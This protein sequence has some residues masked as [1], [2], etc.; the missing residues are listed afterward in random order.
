M[1]L[2]IVFAAVVAAL[3]LVPLT[4]SAVDGVV[5]IDQNKA[6]AGGITPGDAPGFPVTIGRAGSYRLAGNLTLPASADGIVIAESGVT[7]DLNGFSIIGAGGNTRGITDDSVARSR[8][9]VRNGHITGFPSSV[10][11]QASNRVVIEQ[12][13]ADPGPVGLAIVVGPFSRLHQ[14]IAGANGLIQIECPSIATENITDGFV[15]SFVTDASKQ[16][17]RYHNRALNFGASISE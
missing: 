10:R 16:C 4:V 14:N 7:L 9:V 12:L 15:T 2:R 6:L 8:I 11:L 17:V 5:L 1:K 3:A 13:I